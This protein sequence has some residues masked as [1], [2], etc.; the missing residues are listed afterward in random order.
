MN[1]GVQLTFGYDF[2][3]GNVALYLYVVAF[4]NGH[5]KPQLMHAFGF[6]RGKGISTFI[7]TP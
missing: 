6:G 4:C 1:F 2:K 3:T 5:V 7:I